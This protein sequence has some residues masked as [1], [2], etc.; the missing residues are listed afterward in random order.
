MHEL[1]R[2][3][4]LLKKSKDTEERAVKRAIDAEE[5]GVKLKDQFEEGEANI[6]NLKEQ[7]VIANQN[8][9]SGTIQ[10]K[11]LES[12]IVRLKAEEKELKKRNADLE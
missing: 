10:H 6:R 7:I 4:E 12:I 9:S 2:I 1:S 8:I 5:L 11:R 3:A